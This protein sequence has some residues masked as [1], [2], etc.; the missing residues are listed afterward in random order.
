MVFSTHQ[1][2][3]YKMNHILE[4]LDQSPI[5]TEHNTSDKYQSQEIIG[6]GSMIES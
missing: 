3:E 2:K 1:E 6:K 4:Q 5:V